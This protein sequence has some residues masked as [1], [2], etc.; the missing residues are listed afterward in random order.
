M[1]GIS[2]YERGFRF[3]QRFRNTVFLSIPVWFIAAGATFW[4]HEEVFAML[5]RP[6]GGRLSPFEG[7]PIITALPDGFAATLDLSMLAGQLAAF[8]VLVVGT[9]LMLKPFVSKRFWLFVLVYTSL[10][11]GVFVVGDI[12]VFFVMMPVS[13]S[14]LLSFGSNTWEPVIILGQYMALL[15]SLLLWIG[16]AF[17]LPIVMQLLAK[18]RIV[19]YRRAKGLRKW[20]APTAFIF[21][22][23]I[24]PSLNGEITFMVA[25]PMLLLYEFGLIAGW[26]TYNPEGDN[27]FADLPM[28]GRVR[29]WRTPSS[30]S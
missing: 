8:P 10:I 27:Y 3:G 19:S 28:V 9:L 25:I 26:L 22:A 6:A 20:V 5:L 17:E 23:I 16:I 24:T 4:W 18:F 14:F 7:K 1:P 21:A 13:A 15:L 12:F 11:I 29:R 30:P 2:A